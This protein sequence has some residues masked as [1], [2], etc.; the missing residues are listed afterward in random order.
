MYIFFNLAIWVMSYVQLRVKFGAKI[1]S[2]APPRKFQTL[3]NRMK[4]SGVRDTMLLNTFPKLEMKSNI[5]HAT[6]APSKV[7]QQ[8]RDNLGVYL[9]LLPNFPNPGTRSTH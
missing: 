5:V 1:A 6:C 8:S 4:F 9:E 7:M 2:A 3:Q